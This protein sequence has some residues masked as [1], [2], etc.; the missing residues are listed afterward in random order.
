[1]VLTDTDGRQWSPF[2]VVFVC[3]N[4]GTKTQRRSKD[5]RLETPKGKEHSSRYVDFPTNNIK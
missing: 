1:M 3:T 5:W 4:V 2:V